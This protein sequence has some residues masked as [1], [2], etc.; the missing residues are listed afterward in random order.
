MEEEKFISGV[1][2]YY[3]I[4]LSVRYEIHM[5]DEVDGQALQRALDITMTRYPYLKKRLVESSQSFHIMDNDLPVV[6]LNTDKPV[7]LCS[8]ES[9]YHLFCV[10]Y[11][12]DK[13]YFDNSHSLFDGRG[14]SF[15]LH[16][17]M[18]YY[19]TYRYDE[20]VEMPGVLLAGTPIDPLEY[21]DPYS[22]KLPS[23]RMPISTKASPKNV[24]YLPDMGLV[25][26]TKLQIHHI[27]INE[28]QLMALCKSSD[29]T[30]NTAVSLLMCRAIAGLHPDSDKLITAGIYTDLRSVLNSPLTHKPIVVA[31]LIEYTK[32]MWGLDFSTQNTIFRG[33]L[34]L[35]TDESNLIHVARHLK[36]WSKDVLKLPNSREKV[37]AAHKMWENDVK[38]RTFAVSYSGKS[39]FGS[40]DKHFKAFF[41]QVSF[42]TMGLLIEITT[43]D[44]WFYV[45]F[46]QEWK[47]DVYFNA[48]LKEIVKFNLDFDLLYSSEESRAIFPL[49]TQ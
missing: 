21:E 49:H 5:K 42:F 15:I 47:E 23:P 41:P 13:I 7:H 19:C 22:K 30:P 33:Q 48:F 8:P 9:N 14:R 10:S 27:R 36:K 37:A 17:L 18:Y 43:A 25:K 34:M 26:N 35:M 45:T 6:V 32:D 2:W 24:M 4:D 39:S 31:P 3:S 38:G 1:F 29:A 16:T 20:T 44:G 12:D 40:C 46:L 28:K 11:F